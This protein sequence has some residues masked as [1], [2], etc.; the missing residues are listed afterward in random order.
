MSWRTRSGLT[1]VVVAIAALLVGLGRWEHRREVRREAS[2]FRIVESL[3]GRLDG[4]SLS[5]FR[6]L[7]GF[8]CLTYRRAANRYA[9][10]LCIDPAG[11]I[12]EA[13]DRRRDTRRIWSL[14]FD[15]ASS[16]VRVDRGEV[17]RLLR[18]MLA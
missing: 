2:G 6:R 12:V 17:D 4:P 10:E 15:P 3:I 11:R 5:G 14:T 16:P 8:D 9:L 7:P 1:L 18:R 13:I